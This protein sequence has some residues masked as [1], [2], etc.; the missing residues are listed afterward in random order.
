MGQKYTIKFATLAPEGSTWMKVMDEMNAEIS[1]LTDGNV[2]F[3]I[4]PGGVQGD[5]K[6]VMRKIRLGQLHSA[7]F[8]GVGMGEILSEA[9]IM[10]TPFLFRSYE[11]IDYVTK[12]FYDEFSARFEEQGHVMLGWTEVGF[13][14]VYANK[15]LTS[16]SDLKGTKMWM[17][18]GDPVAEATFNA[19]GVSPI[20]L[21]ITDVLTSLQTNLIEAVYTSPLACVTLQWYTRVKYMMNEPLTNAAGVVLISKK[22]FDKMPA[23]YQQILKEKG[24]EYMQKLVELSRRDN[25]ESIELMKKNGIELV[26]IPAQNLEDFRQAGEQVRE[27][28][29][30]KLYSQELLDNVE[31]T[32]AEFRQKTE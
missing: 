18:E 28:L 12:K 23:E 8:T 21:S 14:Y 9:R 27:K 31:Q 20:P 3:K 6:D 2:K 26:E 7:G 10:D 22:M 32:L 30:G 11:E 15:P 24:R 25:R 4:Y 1:K 19:L 16:P 17:W 5:E 13:V 29:V